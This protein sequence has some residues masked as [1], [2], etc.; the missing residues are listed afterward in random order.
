MRCGTYATANTV[1][2]PVGWSHADRDITMD[3]SRHR[4]EYR[5]PVPRDGAERITGGTGRKG[6]KLME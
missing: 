5:D 3:A 6:D 4:P 2:S 1:A